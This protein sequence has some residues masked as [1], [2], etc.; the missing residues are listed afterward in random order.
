MVNIT[1]ALL[2]ALVVSVMALFI[3]PFEIMKRNIRNSKEV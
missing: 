3:I 2:K 1:T